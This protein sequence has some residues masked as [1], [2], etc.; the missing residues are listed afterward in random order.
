MT[1]IASTITAITH[2]VYARLRALAPDAA[3]DDDLD[4]RDRGAVSLE[5][6]LWYAAAATAVGIV[7]T[8]IWTK[9]KSEADKPVVPGGI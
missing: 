1:D 8:V 2:V 9:I 3:L 7:A 5:Q 6:A 4:R